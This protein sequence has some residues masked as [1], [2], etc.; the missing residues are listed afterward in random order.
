MFSLLSRVGDEC[1]QPE[2]RQK[3]QEEKEEDFLDTGGYQNRFQ[4]P[5]QD[6]NECCG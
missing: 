4:K 1:G 6:R 5:Q 3:Q 2:R